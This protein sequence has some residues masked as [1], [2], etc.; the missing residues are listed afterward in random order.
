MSVNIYKYL[1][2]NYYIYLFRS[3][4]DYFCCD[5]C[6]VNPLGAKPVILDCKHI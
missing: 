4:I 3:V 1:I 6:F 5:K 2:K